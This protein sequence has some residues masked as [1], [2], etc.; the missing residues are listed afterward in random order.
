MVHEML[1]GV[2]HAIEEFP[3]DRGL[4]TGGVVG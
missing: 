1:P 2:L 4:C 3:D